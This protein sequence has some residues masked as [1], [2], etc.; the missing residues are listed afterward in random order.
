MF[1][2]HLLLCIVVALVGEARA[3]TPTLD[4]KTAAVH[5]GATVKTSSARWDAEVSFRQS[6]PEAAFYKSS[7][8]TMRVYGTSFAFGQTPVDAA[9]QFVQTH[10][11]MFGVDSADLKPESLLNDRRHTQPVMYQPAT[12]TYKFTLVYYTQSKNGIPVYQAD[13]RLLVRNEA[14]SPLV[15]AASGLRDLGGFSIDPVTLNNLSQPTYIDGRFAIARAAVLAAMPGL[16]RFSA[17][18]AVVWAGVDDMKVQPTV[19]L[20]FIAD[21]A[22]PNGIGD[23]KWRFVTDL[24]TGAILY[25]ENLILQVDVVGNV[26]AMASPDY[27]AD[28]C[29]TE[30][31]M[32][33]P[34]ARVSIGGT[35]VFADANGDFVIPNGGSGQVTVTSE[36]RGQWF[37]VNNQSGV[38]TVLN[39]TVT[40]PGPLNI[41]HNQGNAEFTTAE[42][43]GYIQANVVR[44]VTLASNPSYPTIANQLDW[45]VNVNI[46]DVCNAF[47]D[48]ASI[49]FFTA[50]GGCNNTGFGDVVHHEYGHHLVAVA[51]SGQGQYGEGMGDV[52]GI[53]I[54]GRSQL[55]VG[56]QSCAGGIRDANNTMQYPCSDPGGDP[57]PCGQLISGC[58]WD[59]SNELMMTEPVNWQQIIRDLAINSILMH[60]GSTISPA[61]TTDFLILDD[62]DGDLNNGT[63]HSNEILT[64]FGAHNMVPQPPPANDAC[65]DAIEVCPGITT[66]STVGST[67]DGSATCGDTNS[68]P[69]VWYK[70]TPLTS[71]TVTVSA[72]SGTNYD[73]QLAAYSGC[74]GTTANELACDDDGCGTTG[75][76]STITF[77][78]TAGNTYLIR[79]TGWQGSVG[80]F[81]LN[82]TAPACDPGLPDPLTISFPSGRPATIDPGVA[83]TIPVQI[84]NGTE[85]LVPGSATLHYRYDGGVF[86][87]APLTDLGGG[88]FDATLPAPDCSSL[89]EYYVSANGDGGSTVTDPADAPTTVYAAVVGT[90]TT[91]MTDNFETDQGWVA[92]NQGATSGDWERGVPVDDPGWAYDPT[93]DS[94]GS[95]QAYLTQNQNGNTDVDSGA[96]ALI[97]PTLDLS[98]GNVTINYDYYLRLTDTAGA[99]D[100]LLVEID[101]N[102][103]AGPWIEIARHTTDGGLFWRS[104]VITQ[105]DLDAA[106]VVLTAT[107]KLRFT[108]NDADTQS[109]VESGLDA[110]NI[111][112]VTCTAA[113]CGAADGDFDASGGPN[114][115]DV[116]LFVNALINGATPDEVCH[117]DFDASSALDMGDVNGMV[118]ALLTAP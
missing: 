57:H 25:R 111:S 1:R 46:A 82:I 87:T 23:Q 84:D 114:G 45:P 116:P 101:G 26:S 7:G 102:N 77:S 108:A 59:T 83:T 14:D 60:T 3:Q 69:D 39:P 112:A 68:S 17:P 103:G 98:S 91:V 43:N 21:N 95:G 107:M 27:R 32:A 67:N 74:P 97:S 92:V 118:N 15:S 10:A 66:G 42:V 79:S 105:A 51:G 88:L 93:S 70:Y 29:I 104:N 73:G 18:Q 48:G 38:D 56:F 64:G 61:I 80:D 40:P 34:Y 33:M 110:V 52:M 99:V 75:G 6:F 28:A 5:E 44:D 2:F 106:G 100:R 71:G 8:R 96:V 11:A 24:K 50:G 53:L 9:A 30:T 85:V 49:N 65:I 89:P 12:G 13:L 47:Y 35:T 63:P 4:A 41:L 58:V 90:L 36:V 20:T 78:V 117:G 109:I 76:P 19:A 31:A 37:N 54:T 72:C 115:L 86:L 62:D 113:P 22:G 55:G 81:T 16:T 94:D